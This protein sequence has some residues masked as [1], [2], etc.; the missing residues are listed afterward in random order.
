MVFIK[1]CCIFHALEEGWGLVTSQILLNFTTSICYLSHWLRLVEVSFQHPEG[2]V[3][4]TLPWTGRMLSIDL[5]AH[6]P[7]CETGVCQPLLRKAATSTERDFS[8]TVWPRLGMIKSVSD[9]F[10]VTSSLAYHLEVITRQLSSQSLSLNDFWL[11]IHH[12]TPSIIDGEIEASI[13]ITLWYWLGMG[14]AGLP[15]KQIMSTQMAWIALDNKCLLGM[16][17]SVAWAN[18]FH[19]LK[20]YFSWCHWLFGEGGKTTNKFKSTPVEWSC[21]AK[22]SVKGITMAFIW[23]Y[24][25][26]DCLTVD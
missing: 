20:A 11:A 8:D 21:T 9:I 25:M 16:F 23:Q 6:W 22:H 24:L 10:L 12:K 1:F 13:Q 5:L 3:F 19:R 17:I 4:T 7:F 2:R 18:F 15:L 26:L 14:Q